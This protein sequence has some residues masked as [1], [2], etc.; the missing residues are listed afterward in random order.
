MKLVV[1]GHVV[2]LAAVKTGKAMRSQGQVW[3]LEADAVAN[4]SIYL[5]GVEQNSTHTSN[6][7]KLSHVYKLNSS[8][9]N[10]LSRWDRL[11]TSVEPWQLI[12]PR[13]FSESVNFDMIKGKF[14]QAL[15]KLTVV[16]D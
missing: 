2:H 8:S 4:G 1:T 9:P 3:F 12:G 11:K 13:A 10:G 16:A 7:D 6:T 5:L 15:T 14:S